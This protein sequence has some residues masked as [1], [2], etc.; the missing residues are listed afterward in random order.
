MKK[1]KQNQKTPTRKSHQQQQVGPINSCS[2]CLFCREESKGGSDLDE[3]WI[4]TV[5]GVPGHTS[6]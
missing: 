1:V 3:P 4:M 2:L 5:K 6:E